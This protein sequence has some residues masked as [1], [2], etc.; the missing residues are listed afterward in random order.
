MRKVPVLAA[1]A[2]AGC[3]TPE[4]HAY[5]LRELHEAD[6]STKFV[7]RPMSA[8]S[9]AM[10]RLDGFGVLKG[11][12]GPSFVEDPYGLTLEHLNGLADEDPS[13]PATAG[14]QVEF[15]GWLA[16]QDDYTLAR[17]RSVLE[18]GRAAERLQ[19]HRPLEPLAPGEAATPEELEV[20][21]GRLQD[22]AYYAVAGEIGP[23]SAAGQLR[24]A[25][26]E[27]GGLALDREGM[28]RA[29]DFCTILVGARHEGLA[30]LER[31]QL[32]PLFELHERLQRDFVATALQ[33]VLDD[34]QPIVVAAAVRVVYG[35][36]G[37]ERGELLRVALEHPVREVATAGLQAIA[38]HGLPAA[39]EGST[40]EQRAQHREL[41]LERLVLMTRDLDGR[42]AARACAV[43]EQ[44]SGSGLR[45]LQPEVWRRW[46]NERTE[47]DIR[48]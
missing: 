25:C 48:S 26:D 16:V 33:E 38:E 18:L 27:L 47:R 29:L 43:L 31:A 15:F 46:W 42:L 8:L 36:P 19:V 6:G 37:V 28:R 2:L 17:E 44:I 30:E 22:V 14:L 23:D 24:E 12:D 11:G 20:A 9:W 21:M 5:N 10:R 3:A 39:P 1:V 41:W 40:A 4:F 34:P 32:L 13:N 7:G 35:L 45:S